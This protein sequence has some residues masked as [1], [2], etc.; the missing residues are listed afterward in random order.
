VRL[1]LGLSQYDLHR[2][3]DRAR[4]VFGGKHQT[5]AARHT[6]R[7]YRANTPPLWRGTWA[8]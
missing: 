4:C 2:A 5:L 6:L 3:D 7:L 1:I 8:A